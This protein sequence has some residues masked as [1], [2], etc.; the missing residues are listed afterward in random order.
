M[1]DLLKISRNAYS[2]I[3]RDITDI[4]ESRLKQIAEVLKV[5]TKDI[6]NF[7]EKRSLF[8]ENCSGVM[9]L[10]NTKNKVQSPDKDLQHRIEILE[11]QLKNQQLEIE[12]E[13]AEKALLELEIL[14]LRS[15]N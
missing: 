15:S 7:E 9:G 6:D 3:E 1:A 2:E 10:Y 11:L 13:R 14:K 12:K 4:S 5:S 8:F